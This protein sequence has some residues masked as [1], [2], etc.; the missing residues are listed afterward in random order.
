M[1]VALVAAAMLLVAMPVLS[2]RRSSPRASGPAQEYTRVTLES[3][4]P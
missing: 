4:R 2:A 3:A 1:K